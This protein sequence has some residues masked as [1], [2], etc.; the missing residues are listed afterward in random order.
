MYSLGKAN[1]GINCI[2]LRV[3][4][5]FQLLVCMSVSGNGLNFAEEMK[6]DIANW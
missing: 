6:K 4:Q 2:E 1:Y 3:E 5:K